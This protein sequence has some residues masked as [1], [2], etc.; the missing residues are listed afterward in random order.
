M[1]AFM[2][3][4]RVSKNTESLD[5]TLNTS[6]ITSLSSNVAVDSHTSSI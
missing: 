2:L 6:N 3:L 5:N 4:D 1:T